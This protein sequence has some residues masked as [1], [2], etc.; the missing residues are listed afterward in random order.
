[1]SRILLLHP[2]SAPQNCRYPAPS[3]IEGTPTPEDVVAAELYSREIWM[4]RVRPYSGAGIA[5]T[6]DLSKA[7]A[8]KHLVI[9]ATLKAEDDGAETAPPAWFKAA[10]DTFAQKLDDDVAKLLA[11]LN[12]I[13][14]HGAQSYNWQVSSG[15][16]FPFRMV[17]FPD[18]ADPTGDP[19]NLPLLGN[20]SAVDGLTHEQ[21]EKY[22]AGYFPGDSSTA[23]R[24]SEHRKECIMRAIGCIA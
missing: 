11:A 3:A 24:G 15:N 12:R 8:W 1:M 19:H 10:F 7:L 16:A 4:A 14:S 18:G 2:P 6:S 23:D 17:P 9:E 5:D 22:Y 13:E 21:S 20:K